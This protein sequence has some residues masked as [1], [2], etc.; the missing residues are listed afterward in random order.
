MKAHEVKSKT[1]G[2]SKKPDLI[3]VAPDASISNALQLME[4][5][6]VHH[7]LVMEGE[8]FRGLI[9]ARSLPLTAPGD[10]P[11][12][13]VRVS[14]VMHRNLP[15]ITAEMKVGDALELMLKH[16]ITALPLE[17]NGKIIGVLTETDLLKL[18]NS[19]LGRDAHIPILIGK[20]NTAI[21]NPLVQNL[22][23]LLDSIGL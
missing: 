6:S 5:Y 18:L 19:M 1:G 12:A 20:G 3:S 23:R 15:P 16:Q 14:Q 9:E 2:G 22:M 10:I 17:R 21:A 4:K 13:E 8:F 11:P 7:I